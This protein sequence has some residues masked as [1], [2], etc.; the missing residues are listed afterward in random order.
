MK[1]TTLLILLAT[2][3]LLGSQ[4][5]VDGGEDSAGWTRL[6]L[7]DVTRLVLE[8]NPETKEAEHRWRAARERVRQA[9]AWDD[10][11]VAGESR[12]RRFIDVPPNAF[13]DQSLTLE[14][15]IPITGKNLVRGRSAAAEAFSAFQEARRAQLDVIAKA[16]H[17]LP[18]GECL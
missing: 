18:A 17:L 5:A 11:R 13:M 6:S 15:L 12:V 1:T 9:Y 7:A 4:I 3:L 2:S 10:P 8:N 14:Q 16:R